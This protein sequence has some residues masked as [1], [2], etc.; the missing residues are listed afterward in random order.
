MSGFVSTGGIMTEYLQDLGE[1]VLERLRLLHCTYDSTGRIRDVMTSLFGVPVRCLICARP[2]KWEK[3][4]P[5]EVDPWF[6]AEHCPI[7][8]NDEELCESAGR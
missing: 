6:C 2:L 3:Q 5:N 7:C 8:L 4:I 1:T